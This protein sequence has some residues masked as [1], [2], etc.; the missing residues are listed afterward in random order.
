VRIVDGVAEWDRQASSY[1][2]IEELQAAGDPVWKSL[3]AGALHEL[4]VDAPTFQ[5]TVV[6]AVNGIAAA[7]AGQRVAVVCH[8]GVINAY[9]AHVL[10]LDRVLFFPP[11][12]TG[13][14]RVS[15]ASS[16]VRTLRT[17]NETPHLR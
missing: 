2:P 4:G 9:L 1:I 6:A 16:G 3:A 13:I 7:H 10:G 5:G 17:L 15:V 11:D 8:G 14:N 12:Y